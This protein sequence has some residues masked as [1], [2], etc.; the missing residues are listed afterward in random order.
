MLAEAVFEVDG[1]I[2]GLAGRPQQRA[3]GALG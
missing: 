1:P 3:S 2:T